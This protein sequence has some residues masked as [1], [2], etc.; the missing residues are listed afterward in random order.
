M[1]DGSVINIIAAKEGLRAQLVELDYVLGWILLVIPEIPEINKHWIFKGGTAIR[2]IYFPNWR[3]S[4][5]LDFTVTGRYKPEEIEECLNE[6]AKRL[7]NRSGIRLQIK[8][9]DVLKTPDVAESVKLP[10]TY[11]GPLLKTA[12][13]RSF[14]LDLTFDELTVDPPK[15]LAIKTNYPDQVDTRVSLSVYSLNE[16]LTEKIRSLLQRREPRDLYDVWRLLKEHPQ[17]LNLIE[18]PQNFRKKC[19]HRRIKQVTLEDIFK[20]RTIKILER[21]WEMR[22]KHQ[23]IDLPPFGKVTRETKRLL[24]QCLKE[25]E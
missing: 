2:K 1:I 17:E 21:Q 23:M 13:P 24:K 5:D 7:M 25:A 14:S 15:R 10:L 22:L 16:I 20:D 8:N 19:I 18:L 4:E 12:H 3:Y 9:A 6:L 11:V